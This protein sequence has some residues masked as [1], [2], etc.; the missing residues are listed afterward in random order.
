MP[1]GVTAADP[2]LGSY[3]CRNWRNKLGWPSRPVLT[4]RARDRWDKQQPIPDLEATPAGTGGRTGDGHHG[5]PLPAGNEQV[6]QDRTPAVFV[7]QSDLE[8]EAADQL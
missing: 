3:T 5:L 1:G 6:E 4:R 8:R 2:G 7:H